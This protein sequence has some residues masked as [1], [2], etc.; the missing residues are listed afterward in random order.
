MIAINPLVFSWML[1]KSSLYDYSDC[2]C[3]DERPS[4]VF[5]QQ[6]VFDCLTV[7]LTVSLTMFLTNASVTIPTIVP[8]KESSPL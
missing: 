2:D 5:C 8:S 4:S 6:A 7:F 1:L 3:E